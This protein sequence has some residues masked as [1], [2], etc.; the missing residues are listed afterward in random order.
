MIDSFSGA[1]GGFFA[2][3]ML[4]PIENL[5]T[6]MQASLNQEGATKKE[7]RTLDYLREVI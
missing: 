7:V 3:L 6:R 2:S 4:Y 1:T 5:R